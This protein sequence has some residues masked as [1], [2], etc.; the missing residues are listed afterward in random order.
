[1]AKPETP[2]RYLVSWTLTTADGRQTWYSVGTA[3]LYAGI[4][5]ATPD[6]AKA[7]RYASRKSAE[8]AAAEWRGWDGAHSPQV[9]VG[10]EA[11]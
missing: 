1:M 2:A 10:V 3:G 9:T 11:A 8:R 4:D 6:R 7:R 5:R